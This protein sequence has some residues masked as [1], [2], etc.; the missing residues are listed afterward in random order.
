[1][2]K[3]TLIEKVS[4]DLGLAIAANIPTCGL[5]LEVQEYYSANKQLIPSGIQRGFVL[6]RGRSEY[7]CII[8]NQSFMLGA[9]DGSVTILREESIFA[10]PVSQVLEPHVSKILNG[11]R[12]KTWMDVCGVIK[13]GTFKCI[14]D[15]LGVDINKLCLTQA[16]IVNIADRSDQWL[17]RHVRNFIF[18]RS[19]KGRFIVSLKMTSREKPEITTCSFESNQEL[20]LDP[21]GDNCRFIIPS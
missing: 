4:H 14:Y 19:K 21:L 3:G 12:A 5:P 13:R 17:G 7:L 6:S 8:P 9:S 10:N 16:Q 20:E 2:S 1:M 18:C 15:S 11:A